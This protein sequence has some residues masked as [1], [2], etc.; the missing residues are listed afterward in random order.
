MCC[1]HDPGYVFLSE[2]D[3]AGLSGRLQMSRREFEETYCRD[4]EMDGYLRLSLKEQPNNDCVFWI[5]GGCSVY[6]D[7]PLQCRSFPFWPS[8]LFSA[9]TWKTLRGY[10][11]G[12]G[13]GELHG[14]EEIDAWLRAPARHRY[15]R[16]RKP[17]ISH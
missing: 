12:V 11:P 3:L 17:G 5:D 9:Y 1:R 10:C 2:E 4:V 14:P 16:R 13:I 6:E 15:I 8:Y 7:R